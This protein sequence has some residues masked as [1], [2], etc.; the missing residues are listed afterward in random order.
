MIISYTCHFQYGEGLLPIHISK[1][2]PFGIVTLSIGRVI[3][4]S[5]TSWEVATKA[6]LAE[7]LLGV[8]VIARVCHSF[9]V[10]KALSCGGEEDSSFKR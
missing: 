3:P 4:S 9:A 6:L 7:L 5:K 2:I 8:L 10:V 1:E